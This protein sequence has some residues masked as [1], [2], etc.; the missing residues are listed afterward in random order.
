MD[1]PHLKDTRFPN[2]DTVDV[3]KFQ[4]TFD[5]MRWLPETKIKLVNV[6]WNSDYNDTVKFDTNTERDAYFDALSDYYALQLDT[7]QRM[8]PDA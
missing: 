1:F 6:L 7:D 4:N 3:Y 5:Y 2:F 8:L